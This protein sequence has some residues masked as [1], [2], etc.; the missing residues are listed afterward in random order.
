MAYSNLNSLFYFLPYPFKNLSASIVGY[1]KQRQKYGK[2]FQNYYNFLISSNLKTQKK[3]SYEELEEFLLYMRKKCP[4]YSKR[5]PKDLDLKTT[6]IIDKNI[7]IRNYN[8]IQMKPPFKTGRTS[9]TTGQPIKVPY[10]KI[11]YQKEYAFWWYHRTFGGV[12]IGDKIA[13]IAGHKVTS[14]SRDGPPFWIFN[15][16]DNQIFFSSYHLSLKNIPHYVNKLNEFK[17][18][19]IHGYPSSIYLLAKFILEN[20][21]QIQFKPKMIVTSS[22]ATFDFQR[23]TIEQAFKS[24]VYI[25]YGNIECC[26][27]ITECSY[28][29]L[30]LQ[31]YHSHVRIIKEDGSDA[32]KNETGRLIATNFSN[33]AFPLIN[34]DT[35]DI[36]KISNEQK[37]QCD[38][39]GMVLESII[40]RI[41]DFI[42][43]PEGRVIVRLGH[44]FKDVKYI[45]NAQ[46]EQNNPKQ[47]VIRIEQEKKYSSV[48]ERQVLR[49]ARSRLGNSMEINF[50]YVNEICKEKNGKFKFIVQKMKHND[51]AEIPFPIHGAKKKI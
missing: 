23:R 10:T 45:R 2:F 9:G 20:Q 38:S 34:Y 28:G 6:P 29:K 44:L 13:T 41:E 50:E 24:K 26:G 51:I 37:C 46:I 40:G 17:P 36:V 11:A 15:V 33:Y 27:H 8:A 16:A 35:K 25:F 1:F 42:V 32:G 31:P 49:E 18:E 30:H 4:F 47:I 39:G 7:V 19:L 48:I 22:E 3:K 14:A 5:I 12:K 21:L 43:T